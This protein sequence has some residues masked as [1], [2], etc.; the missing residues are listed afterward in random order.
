MNLTVKNHFFSQS[1]VLC[2]QMEK[3]YH[4]LISLSIFTRPAIMLSVCRN[5]ETPLQ[6]TQGQPNI[7]CWIQVISVINTLTRP[8]LRKSHS[9][10]VW[11][12]R[13]P[14]LR[15]TMNAVPLKRDK[16]QLWVKDCYQRQRWTTWPEGKLRQSQEFWLI[17]L[18]SLKALN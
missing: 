14:S 10:A 2:I 11:A 18:K 12:E 9:L 13:L 3:N 7:V 15:G 17:L 5:R 4:E 8:Q 1:I 6:Q 16:A